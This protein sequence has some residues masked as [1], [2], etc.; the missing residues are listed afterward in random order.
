V[1]FDELVKS[2]FHTCGGYDYQICGKA[3]TS[4]ILIHSSA[5]M[6]GRYLTLLAAGKVQD[7]ATCSGTRC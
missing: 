1:S 4:G 5:S 7:D 2:S 6:I 3:S